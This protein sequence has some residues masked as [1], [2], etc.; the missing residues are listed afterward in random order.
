MEPSL[1]LIY[2]THLI[3]L[4][5]LRESTLNRSKLAKIMQKPCLLLALMIAQ[6]AYADFIF[7]INS[8]EGCAN[9]S[10]TWSGKGTV[11]HWLVGECL[12]EGIGILSELDAQGLFTM[13]VKAMREAGITLCPSYVEK[14]LTGSC[15]QGTV[16]FKTPYGALNGR[17]DGNVGDAAGTLTVSPGVNV[18]VKAHFLRDI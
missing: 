11:E 16:V 12:Y 10:G 14:Q 18:K 4:R 9:L 5:N 17:M 3:M 7:T 6:S 13:T 1:Y 2:D 15:N 8:A